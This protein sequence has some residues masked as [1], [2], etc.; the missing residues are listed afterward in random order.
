MKKIIIF[1]LD[2]TLINTVD[3]INESILYL[4]NKENLD[5]NLEKYNY[6]QWTTIDDLFKIFWITEDQKNIFYDFEINN[7]KRLIKLYNWV[8]DLLIFLKENNFNLAILTSR[9]PITT[10]CYLKHLNIISFFDTIIDWSFKYNKPNSAW[11]DFILKENNIKRHNSLYIGD[12]NI[13]FETWLNA[14][15]ETIIVSWWFINSF[16]NS[17][18]NINKLKETIIKKFNL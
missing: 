11:I 13:D 16:S 12:T 5:I 8:Y 15:I 14:K 7:Y 18:D 9:W 6:L 1:D 4:K 3:L 2:G 17:I 10:N